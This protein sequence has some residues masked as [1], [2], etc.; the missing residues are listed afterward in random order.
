MPPAPPPAPA[1]HPQVG[2]LCFQHGRLRPLG[3]GGEH[4]ARRVQERGGVRDPKLYRLR[5]AAATADELVHRWARRPSPAARLA[6]CG[7]HVA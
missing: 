4:T 6:P 3:V 1:L 7:P 5:A 2:K